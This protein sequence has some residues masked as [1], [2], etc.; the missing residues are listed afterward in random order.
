MRMQKLAGSAKQERGVALVVVVLILMVLS[1][2]GAALMFSVQ[3]ETKMSGHD[4]RRS[5]A[6]SIA[7]AGVSEGIARIRS[8]EVPDTLNPKMAT[9]IF[10]VNA[11]G[12][13]VLGADSTAMPTAQPAGQWL[14]YS[15]A[16]RSDRVLTVTYKT[17]ATRTK[18]YRYDPTRDPAV[19]TTSGQ[20]IFVVTATGRAGAETRTV[21]S[22]IVRKPMPVNLKAA[23]TSNEDI[24]FSGNS[25]ICGFNHYY[26][27]PLWYGDRGR[28]GTNSCVP[29]ET[30]SG[31]LPGS[32]TTDVTYNGGGFQDGS[33][34]P[35]LSNQTGFYAG[36]WEALGMGQAEFYAWMGTPRNTVPATLNGIVYLDN[37]AIG[38]NR[39]GSWS[40]S[41]SNG[42]GFLYVDGD[43]NMT[44]AFTYKGLIYIEGSLSFS[45]QSWIL[46]G[47][48]E[49][50]EGAGLKISGG[51]T[52]LYS[53]ETVELELGKFGGR[54]GTLSWRE[55]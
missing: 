4:Q 39:S 50:G 15:T 19:Q 33:P 14:N 45:S 38:Q 25:A 42:E 12:V 20:P 18:I 21:V 3:T 27:T 2:I 43:M 53:S 54:F 51:A 40:M 10:L 11:G 26:A 52:V 47:V 36:P 5:E 8:G 23:V 7:E 22:E 31:D 16:G 24:R 44:G 28:A 34:D 1:A 41:G 55:R 46:G 37:D 13:P 6:L 30:L 17:D 49:H 9:Q 29:Y 48:V 32:W 35:S